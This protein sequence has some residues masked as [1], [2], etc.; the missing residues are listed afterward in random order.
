M[1]MKLPP[2]ALALESLGPGSA[3]AVVLTDAAGP[4]FAHR[5]AE[6]LGRHDHIVFLCGHYEGVDERVAELASH[7]FSLGDFVMTGGELAAL[8]MADATVRLLPGVLG[9]AASHQD[10]SHASDGLLGHPLYTRPVEWRGQGT[11]E[12]LLSGDH[13]RIAAWRRRESLRRTRDLRPDLFCRARL[14]GP[15]RGL[16]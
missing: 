12:V 10:D 4:R 15:D 7:R 11:P 14:V 5:D 6:E 3:A 16:L 8:A 13:G 2:I 1:V 9:D